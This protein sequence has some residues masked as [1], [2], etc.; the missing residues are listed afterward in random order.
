MC[1]TCV[2]GQHQST[3]QRCTRNENRSQRPKPDQSTAQDLKEKHTGCHARS[4]LFFSF[5]WCVMQIVRKKMSE[6][7]G[8]RERER[9]QEVLFPLY[10]AR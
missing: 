2:E 5:F 10:S 9:D 4:E 3:S 7:E 1:S 6:E 8:V